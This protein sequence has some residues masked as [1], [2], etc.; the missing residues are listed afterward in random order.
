LLE[1]VETDLRKLKAK[2]RRPKAD[3]IGE[4]ALNAAVYAT[5]CP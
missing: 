3:N 5:L 4:L 2:I 1:D